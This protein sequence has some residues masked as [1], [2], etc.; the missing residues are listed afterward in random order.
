MLFVKDILRYQIR[1]ITAAAQ[2]H[3]FC[4]LFSLLLSVFLWVN[5]PSP[6]LC[7]NRKIE[8]KR[9]VVVT[10][11]GGAEI[12]NSLSDAG[13]SSQAFALSKATIPVDS[14]SKNV[15]AWDD[16]WGLQSG[17]SLPADNNSARNA[18]S[19]PLPPSISFNVS[20]PIQMP[21]L[22]TLSC[23]NPSATL[24]VSSQQSIT[25]TCALA[26]DVEWPPRASMP[27][28]QS[29]DAKKQQLTIMMA[30]PPSSQGLDDIDPFADWPPRPTNAL[31]GVSGA[32]NGNTASAAAVINPQG[33]VGSGKTSNNN[34]MFPVSSSNSWDFSSYQAN[35]GLVG[36]SSLNPIGY[37]RQNQG[38]T[39]LRDHAENKSA[40]IGSIFVTN[41]NEQAGA[42]RLAPPPSTAVGRGRGRGTHLQLPTSRSSTRK[43]PSEQP[44]V[45]DLL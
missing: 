24:A 13:L 30:E 44:P 41:K 1:T 39:T 10:E 31:L 23:S 14:A 12:K 36:N 40:N 21:S 27:P 45:L 4:F 28:F 25:A 33:L 16:G 38:S 8:E 17:G 5:P 3:T 42:L 37:S 35:S 29:N 11:T 9:S 19:V 26:A 20:Q 43:S 32:S 18:V 34:S 2:G 7:H 22:Q 6:L 15:P